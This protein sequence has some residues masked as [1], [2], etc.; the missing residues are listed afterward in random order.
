MV[1]TREQPT[2]AFSSPASSSSI[3]NPSADPTPRPPLT[4]TLASASEMPAEG[5]SA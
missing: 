2:A 3:P 1:T 5:V 4:T